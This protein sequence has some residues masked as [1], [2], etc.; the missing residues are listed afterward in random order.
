MNI[1]K[2]FIEFIFS[3]AMIINAILFV[4]QAIRIYRRKSAHDISF[5]TF[6]GFSL[7]QFAAILHGYITQD[8][9][10]MYGTLISFIPC[11]IVTFLIL[12]Y[13]GRHWKKRNRLKT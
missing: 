12:F 1:V 13:R 11:M 3:I 2:E 4:P 7:I 9:L 6:A 10:L 5:I 8:Y